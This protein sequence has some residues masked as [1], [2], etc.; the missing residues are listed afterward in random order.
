MLDHLQLGTLVLQLS[1]IA[2]VLTLIASTWKGARPGIVVAGVFGVAIVILT[3]VGILHWV[4]TGV[5]PKA[6]AMGAVLTALGNYLILWLMACAIGF[7]LG[8]AIFR[9]RKLMAAQKANP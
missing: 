2:A 3:V 7:G 1:G 9:A 5:I 4:H 6:E 8:Y